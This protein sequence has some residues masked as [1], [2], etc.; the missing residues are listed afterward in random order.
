MTGPAAAASAHA[1]T[2]R[3]LARR[4]RVATTRRGVVAAAARARTRAPS[5]GRTY[6]LWPDARQPMI[7][8]DMGYPAAAEWLRRTM[9]PTLR[10]LPDAATW[11]SLRARAALLGEEAGLAAEVGGAVTKAVAPLRVAMFSP[12]GQAVSKVICFLFRE[13]EDEPRIV[14]KA[15]AEPRFSWRLRRESVLLESIRERVLRDERVSAGLPAAP[16]F[17]GDAAGEFMLAEP[18]DALGTATGD[19]TRM[20]ALE[21]LRLFQLASCSREQA[22]CSDDERAWLTAAEDAWRLAAPG[23]DDAVVS[24]VR[25]LLGPLRGAIVPRCAV[26]GDFWRGNVAARDGSIRVFD[27]EWA[28]L[29]G[30]PFFDLWTFELAEPSRA[31]ARR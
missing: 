13:G 10:R 8:A 19:G 2:L 4:G 5:S 29:E 12:S 11:M 28:A 16:L 30:S 1:I 31:R 18:C 15:M 20:Q 23:R 14:V 17:A 27:W 6:T 24:R 7:S 25:E 9:V 26:H 22:W 21:W 3:L